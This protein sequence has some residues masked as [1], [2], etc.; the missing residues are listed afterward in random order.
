MVSKKK[1]ELSNLFMYIYICEYFL[2][3]ATFKR[4]IYMS[5]MLYLIKKK[6]SFLT[7]TEVSLFCVSGISCWA[8]KFF[9]Q[10]VATLPGQK[11]TS[12]KRKGETFRYRYE[13]NGKW[14][15]NILD[16]V[17][18]DVR[19]NRVKDWSFDQITYYV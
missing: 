10:K 15:L 18:Q 17:Y 4:I 11:I 19:Q 8:Q 12:S 13:V 2:V 9:T 5:Q 14:F 3:K 6:T 1:T 7:R 16:F